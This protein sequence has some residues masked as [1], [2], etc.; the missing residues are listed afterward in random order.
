MCELVQEFMNNTNTLREWNSSYSSY[1]TP[2]R[3]IMTTQNFCDVISE[4]NYVMTKILLH[5]MH[6]PVITLII[7]TLFGK[8]NEDAKWFVFHTAVLNF[9]LGRLDSTLYINFICHYAS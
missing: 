8:E 3:M 7:I 9:I 6:V 2:E 5:I 1:A 4:I